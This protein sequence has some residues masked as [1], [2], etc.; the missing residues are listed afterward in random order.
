MS[1][2]HRKKSNKPSKPRR[3][4]IEHD[5]IGKLQIPN[6][7]YYGI[8]S[9]RAKQNFPITGFPISSFPKLIRG[10]AAI[11]KAA[12]QTNRELDLLSESRA[13]AICRACD[14]IMEDKLAEN[15]I[16]DVVQ[17]GAGTSTNMNL[18]EVIANRAL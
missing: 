12:A 11:K 3:Y 13:T 16:V 15:F 2:Q 8:H 6:E 10:L 7:A 5:F 18:N 1:V 14:E 9:L 17:G 4:R